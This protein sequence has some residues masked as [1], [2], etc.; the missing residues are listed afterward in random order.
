M[1]R[2]IPL[3]LL[4]FGL[5]IV[6]VL[7]QHTLRPRSDRVH[8]PRPRRGGASARAEN[9]GPGANWIV[10][11]AELV[12]VRDAYS[13]A[14]ID[15]RAPLWRCGGCQAC[16]HQPSIAALRSQNARRCALCG[17]DDLRPVRVV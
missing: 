17:S 5:L 7:C 10:A 12:G 13:S 11:A 14:A 16:Y 15:P 6:A 4:L 8:R 9:A 1:A 3:L 2:L